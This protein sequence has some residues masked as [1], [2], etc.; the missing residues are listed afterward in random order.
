[1]DFNQT[2]EVL[3]E[4]PGNLVYHLVVT[5]SVVMLFSLV[6]LYPSPAI[7]HQSRWMMISTALLLLQV[8][9]LFVGAASRLISGNLLAML[10][11]L[12]RFLSLSSLGI[13][14]WG[15]IFPK[16]SKRVNQIV[17]A[18]IATGVLAVL[19]EL[20]IAPDP[21]KAD[22]VWT[23]LGILGLIL[24]LVRVTIKRPEQWFLVQSAVVILLAGYFLHLAGSAEPPVLQGMV[25]WSELAAYPL[26]ALA[27]VRSLAIESGG[28]P[29]GAIKI[30]RPDEQREVIAEHRPENLL[31]EIGELLSANRDESLA[32]NAVRTVATILRAEMCLL[33]TPPDLS[34]QFAIGAAYDLIQEH[35]L[36]GAPLESST[37]PILAAALSRRKPVSLS[38]QSHAPDLLTLQQTLNI[39]TAGSLMMVPM[40]SRGHLEGG[41]LLLSPFTRKRWEDDERRTVEAFAKHLAAR[42]RQ[43]RNQTEPEPTEGA[44]TL[45]QVV[46][47]EEEIDR[48][49]DML[50]ATSED[51]RMPIIEPDL[52]ALLE[53]HEEAQSTIQALEAEIQRLSAALAQRTELDAAAEL[54]QMAENH[55]NALQELA[56]T[57]AQLAHARL[58]ANRQA[59]YDP[60]LTESLLHQLRQPL[61]SL[62]GHISLLREQTAGKLEPAQIQLLT[63][64]HAGLDRS[65]A[66]VEQLARAINLDIAGQ[67][68]PSEPVDLMAC[69]EKAVTQ[70]GEQ[71]RTRNLTLRMDFPESLPY[72]TGSPQTITN[73]FIHLINNAIVASPVQAE[74]VISTDLQSENG[75]EFL[76]CSITDQGQGIPPQDIPSIFDPKPEAAHAESTGEGEI[77]VNLAEVKHLS[78]SIG[79]RVWVESQVGHGTTF[80]VLLPLAIPPHSESSKLG[81]NK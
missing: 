67:L 14:A 33:L 2:A 13:F 62:Q 74:V 53:M 45:A 4:F 79:G 48:L 29:M 55:Q 22:Q 68:P 32:K 28:L 81:G 70:S 43:L 46:I 80:T 3:I 1:M 9:Y 16:P 69:L 15:F 73:I 56:T 36:G 77:P 26:F 51:G 58:K 47:L 7:G 64:I 75:A 20:L 78:E 27:A 59:A 42:F 41:I 5:M 8:I 37:C 23:I 17:A 38:S 19:S 24:I 34:G 25:R 66:V 12:D 6:R 61:S 30:G 76:T 11:S 35:F 44:E 65:G 63:Q 60:E 54:E 18:L 72:V 49:S 39:D 40:V 10:P 52:T 71:I 50:R 57:R 31:P 21:R